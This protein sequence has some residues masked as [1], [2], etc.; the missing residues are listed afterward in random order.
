MEE[1]HYGCIEYGSKRWLHK[2]TII[3]GSIQWKISPPVGLHFFNFTDDVPVKTQKNKGQKYL[4]AGHIN[5]IILI[6]PIATILNAKLQNKPL[7]SMVNDENNTSDRRSES[8]S[9]N[10]D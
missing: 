3:F 7:R 8:L 10:T 5:A 4:D 2:D 6:P 1:V 9:L